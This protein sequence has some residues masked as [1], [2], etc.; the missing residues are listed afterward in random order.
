MA[1]VSRAWLFPALDA[2]E[3]RAYLLS[4]VGILE[5]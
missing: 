4:S 2:G 3:I 1:S 5:S